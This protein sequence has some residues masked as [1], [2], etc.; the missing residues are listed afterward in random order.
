[1]KST[2][3]TQ[4]KAKM[5]DVRFAIINGDLEQLKSWKKTNSLPRLAIKGGKCSYS[6][7]VQAVVSRQFEIVKW[8]VC[9]NRL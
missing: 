3:P 8:L 2:P 6:P 5:P 9:V 1:M 4:V 7:L